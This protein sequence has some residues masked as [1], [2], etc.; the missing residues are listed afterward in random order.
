VG[1]VHIRVVEVSGSQRVT[2]R[3]LNVKA[4]LFVTDLVVLQLQQLI[5]HSIANYIDPL[6]QLKGFLP[7][8]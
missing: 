4:F 7:S 5:V 6:R 8:D 2:A 1:E 3:E